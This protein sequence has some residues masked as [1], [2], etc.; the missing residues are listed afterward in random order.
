MVYVLVDWDSNVARILV[1]SAVTR[2]IVATIPVPRGSTGVSF[3]PDGAYAYVKTTTCGPNVQIIDTLANQVVG[4]VPETP[5][6]NDIAFRPDGA[7]AYITYYNPALTTS[8][9]RVIDTGTRRVVATIRLS[10][11]AAWTYGITASSVGYA[12]VEA[13]NQDFTQT[14]FVIYTLSN[15]VIGTVSGVTGFP[16]LLKAM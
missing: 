11:N 10:D 4:E 14:V 12:Y 15:N 6:A 5:C 8:G 13:S 9:V 3:G 7:A 1:I 16:G 2:E